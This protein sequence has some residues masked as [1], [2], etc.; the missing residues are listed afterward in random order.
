MRV[1]ILIPL[2]LIPI[3]L[4]FLR[5]IRLNRL[6]IHHSKLLG[7]IEV[8]QKYN[9]EKV[10]TTNDYPQGVS[11]H[12]KSIEMSYWYKI[13]FKAITHTKSLKNP[14][15]L[16]LGLGANT[17]SNLIAKLNPNIHQ[18]IVELDPLIIQ[19]C[20]EHFGLKNLHN[21][22][23]IN[24]DAY[25]WVNT[26]YQTPGARYQVIIVDIFLGAPPYL[27]IKSNQPTFI[28]KLL[29]LLE[30][31]GIMIFNRPAHTEEA[32]SQSEELKVYLKTLFKKV[33]VFDIQDPRGF[34]NHVITGSKIK[35]V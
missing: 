10:L 7:K 20:E 24:A 9:G 15:I 13:A 3:L 25:K 23:V 19:A 26:S 2:L 34:R 4:Y 22:K 31:Q 29:P 12:N 27:D 32:R 18:T 1:D 16:M 6:A 14:Q 33:E 11:I 8:F 30:N 28:K 5:R 35:S 17:I 21:I